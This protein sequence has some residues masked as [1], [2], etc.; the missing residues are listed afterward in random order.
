MGLLRNLAVLEFDERVECPKPA[1]G[2]AEVT[3]RGT[4]YVMVASYDTASAMRC[5]E[6]LR[7]IL[8]GQTT[9]TRPRS[10]IEMQ[11]KN[12][13]PFRVDPPHHATRLLRDIPYSPRL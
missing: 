9:G 1:Y 5:A 12:T 13:T 2:S 10:E 3:S 4:A 6:Y 7:K 8:D 11:H